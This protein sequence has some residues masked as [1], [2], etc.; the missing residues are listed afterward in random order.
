MK[1]RSSS[2]IEAWPP[3]TFA[4]TS[5]NRSM[6]LRDLYPFVLAPTV[7]AKLAFVHDR[8]RAHR[9]RREVPDGALKAMLAGLRQRIGSPGT[10]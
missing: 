6:G 8:I 9:D 5:I 4:V 3:V 10:A 7:I 2:V 1:F